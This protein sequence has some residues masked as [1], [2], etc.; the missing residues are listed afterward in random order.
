MKKMNLRFSNKKTYV[1]L[2]AVEKGFFFCCVDNPLRP[3]LGEPRVCTQ[4]FFL[5][6]TNGF[7][8]KAK[9]I[10]RTDKKEKKKKNNGEYNRA[11]QDTDGGFLPHFLYYFFFLLVLPPVITKTKTRSD[12]YIF[13]FILCG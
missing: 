4:C 5:V 11:Q 9:K 1:E 2:C 6:S 8:L 12:I 10:Y 3:P 13:I 7:F